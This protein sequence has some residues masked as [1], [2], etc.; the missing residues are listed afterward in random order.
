MIAF[1]KFLQL[2]IPKAIEEGHGKCIEASKKIFNAEHE[3]D[4][5]AFRDKMMTPKMEQLFGGCP[6]YQYSIING[7]ITRKISSFRHVNVIC[8]TQGFK[9]L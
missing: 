3:G 1:S 4:E 9:K 5:D 7:E 6:T 2:G 8:R